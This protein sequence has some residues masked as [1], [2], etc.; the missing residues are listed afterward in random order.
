MNYFPEKDLSNQYVSQS[1]YDLLQKHEESGLLYIV[2]GLG[3]EVFKM[4][5]S[6]SIITSNDTASY[7]SQ[8]ISSSYSLTSSYASNVPLT[9]S[10]AI[11]S[12]TSSFAN[13]SLVSTYSINSETSSFLEQSESINKFVPIW[14]SGSLTPT[15]SIYVDNNSVRINTTQE[16]D[17]ASKEALLVNQ[18][19]PYSVNVIS[20][21]GNADSFLQLNIQNNSTGSHASSDIVATSNDGDNNNNYVDLGINSS[22]YNDPSFE[23]VGYHDA[24]LYVK[25]G[26]LAIGTATENKIIKLHTGG[27]LEEN[28]RAIIDDTGLHATGSLLGTASHSNTTDSASYAVSSSYSLQTISGSYALSSSYASNVPETASYASIARTSSVANSASYIIPG[29]TFYLVSGSNGYSPAYIE[30]YDYCTTESLY[31]PPFKEGRM[32]W[33]HKYTDYA[34]YMDTNWR[35]HLGKEISIGVYNP[36]PTT[37][38]RM[39]AVYVSGSANGNYQPNVHPAVADGTGTKSDVIGV[40]R[41]DIPPYSTGFVHMNGVMHRTDMTP[42]GA[43]VGESLWLSPTIPGGLT[44]IKPGE[45]NEVVLVGYVSESGSLGSFITSVQQI[46]KPANAYAGLTSYP[47]IIDNLTSSYVTVG[48]ASVN[49]Y[50]NV[51]GVGAVTQYPLDTASFYIP[52]SENASFIYATTNGTSASYELTYNFSDINGTN[53]VLVSTIYRADIDLHK[54]QADRGGLALANKI[55]RRLYETQ[56]F[57]RVSGLELFATGSQQFGVTAGDVWFGATKLTASYYDSA[58]TESAYNPNIFGFNPND[59]NPPHLI[60]HDETHWVY[61]SASVWVI[62]VQDD[63]IYNNAYYDDGTNLT[64]LTTDYY[65]VNY[66]YRILGDNLID[67]DVFIVIGNNEYSNVPEAQ[68]DK[69]PSD[70]PNVLADVSILVGRMIVKS[71]SSSPAL[72]ESAFTNDFG[73]SVINN[74]NNLGGLQGGTA[75]QYYHL[76]NNEYVGTGTGVFVKKS[77]ATLISAIV[78]GSLYGTSSWSSNASISDTASYINANDING[79]ISSSSYAM[80]SSYSVTASYSLTTSYIDGGYY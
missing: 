5:S 71:G 10:Y 31:R 68:Q 55:E 49:L 40:I 52:A 62:P 61:H 37:M 66:F 48:T 46:P 43:R 27:T 65:T 42:Y 51:E 75:G 74:H 58:L 33:D 17:L 18:T 25:G 30:P 72:V 24:Y 35:I 14:S 79:T 36:Y 9:A 13:I 12:A 29:A 45:P 63:G 8:S 57:V 50:E 73:S 2:D 4:T 15:S 26:N 44:K 67:E 77:G 69:V 59:I 6:A 41:N 22:Q 28:T 80:S 47:E 56:K 3:N 38:S 78:S 16:F 34:H 64:P 53:K 20:G 11:K 60:H 70:I 76:T 7:A 23:N 32:V 19:D 1:Y 54:M 21:I 39:T